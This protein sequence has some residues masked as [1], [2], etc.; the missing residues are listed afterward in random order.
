MDLLWFEFES[1]IFRLVCPIICSCGELCLLV[2]WCVGDRCDMAD[3]DENLR[4]SR[5]SGAEDRRRSSTVGY[6]VVGRLGGRMAPCGVCTVH[7]EM[8]SADFLVQPQN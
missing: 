5:R 6:S 1:R 3:I 2:S 4:R 7:K 8:S